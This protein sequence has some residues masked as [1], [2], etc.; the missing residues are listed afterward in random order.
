M[1]FNFPTDF[2]ENP[3]AVNIS[4]PDPYKMNE[5]FLVCR[6]C[7]DCENIESGSPCKC[8]GT[9]GSVHLEC[10][11]SWI[12]HKFTDVRQAY[13][14]ICKEKY[15]IEIKSSVMKKKK[16]ED[17]EQKIKFQCKICFLYSTLIILIMI[18]IIV[19]V[20]IVDFKG[21]L[22]RSLISV[23]FCFFMILMNAIF[24]AKVYIS[25]VFEETI[26]SWTIIFR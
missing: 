6:I 25:N 5:K 13:C 16:I 1:K 11:K 12:L 19:F 23:F 26:K 9:Q 20:Q 22:V 14:E 15:K 18:T 21:Q 17:S 4:E 8:S 2:S 10:L 7:Y 3:C 24:I